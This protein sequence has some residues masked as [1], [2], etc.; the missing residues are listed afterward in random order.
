[1]PNLK[2]SPITVLVNSPCSF[3]LNKYCTVWRAKMYKLK[4]VISSLIISLITFGSANAEEDAETRLLE[5]NK[6]VESDLN[7]AE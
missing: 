7:N 4:P 2:L 5:T 6:C 1:M 3:K